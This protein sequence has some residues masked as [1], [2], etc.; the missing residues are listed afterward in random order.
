MSDTEEELHFLDADAAPTRSETH[1]SGARVDPRK[2]FAGVGLVIAAVVAWSVLAPQP[3]EPP[4]DSSEGQAS[5]ATDV[6]SSISTPTVVDDVP[7]E[8]DTDTQ[9]EAEI[10]GRVAAVVPGAEGQRVPVLTPSG[11]LVGS[12]LVPVADGPIIPESDLSLMF[13]DFSG[14]VEIADLA[15]GDR[16]DYRL[17]SGDLIVQIDN[18]LVFQDP[19]GGFVLIVDAAEFDTGEFDGEVLRVEPPTEFAV[20]VGA[21]PVSDGVATVLSTNLAGDAMLVESTINLETG[22]VI[23]ERT[24]DPT[25]ARNSLVSAYASNRN[26]FSP[27]AGGVYESDGDGSYRK[28]LN[29]RLLVADD[30]FALVQNCDEDLSCV[31][32][33]HDV[34]TWDALLRPMPEQAFELGLLFGEGRVIVH[35]APGEKALSIFD[36]ELGRDV[37]IDGSTLG[38]GL[39]VSPSGELVAFVDAESDEVVVINLDTLEQS[40]LDFESRQG[41]LAFVELT[42]S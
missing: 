6:E 2:F 26:A 12:G 5:E 34:R 39:A 11:D 15:T 28:V 7:S 24:V 41:A 19:V 25:L 38:S 30:R 21:W 8:P 16:H 33:W 17:V 31:R 3:T 23:E 18:R 40:R 13:I 14:D 1:V 4:A 9:V 35:V 10:L 29:G 42:G 20:A 32:Q 36:V 22:A 37:P 27:E